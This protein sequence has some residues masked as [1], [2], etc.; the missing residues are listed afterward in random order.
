MYLRFPHVVINRK[1]QNVQNRA[2]IGAYSILQETSDAL[3]DAHDD[4]SSTLPTDDA[5]RNVLI[6]H[7]SALKLDHEARVLMAEA[8]RIEWIEMR[9]FTLDECL[10]ACDGFR[11]DEATLL[12]VVARQAAVEEF[13][14]KLTA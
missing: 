3:L 11:I 6:A 9:T 10:Q 1:F 4:L 5:Y 8:I 12:R 13:T 7:E 14:A 2:L